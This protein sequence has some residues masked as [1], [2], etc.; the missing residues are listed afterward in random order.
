M[1]NKDK[2]IFTKDMTITDIVAIILRESVDNN[3]SLIETVKEGANFNVNYMIGGFVKTFAV[4][5]S[6]IYKDVVSHVKILASLSSSQINKQDGDFKAK[7]HDK[8]TK[9]DVTT[10][11]DNDFE[12]IIIK[13]S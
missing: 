2:I 1:K 5:P 7:I 4:I 6:E 9:F 8:D 12:K 3:A 10:L 11:S 13:L